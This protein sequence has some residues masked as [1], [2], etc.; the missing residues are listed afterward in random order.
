VAGYANPFGTDPP[1]GYNPDQWK[2]WYL[3]TTPEA[4]WVQY[5]QD[6]GLYGVDPAGKYA[7]NQYNKVYGGYGA[8]AATNPN[9][10]FYDY[11][12]GSG[13]DLRGE[14]ANQSPTDRGDF[15]D[16]ILTPRVRFMRA[17]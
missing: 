16:R 10:G 7:R 1:P 15:S 17:Y 3:N 9:L 6:Q 5:L 12:L 2:A 13:L 4:G 14:Y 8:Q 11:L